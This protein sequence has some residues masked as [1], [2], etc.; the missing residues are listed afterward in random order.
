MSLEGFAEKISEFCD[1]GH[2]QAVNS[3]QIENRVPQDL[4]TPELCLRNRRTQ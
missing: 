1:R 3:A 2:P 4:D